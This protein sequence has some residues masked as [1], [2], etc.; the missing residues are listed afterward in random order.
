MKVKFEV[1]EHFLPLWEKK[2]RYMI[3]MGGRGRGASMAISQYLIS[4]LVS[5]GYVRVAIMRSIYSDIRHSCWKELLD[6]INEQEIR[7][8]L[9][10]TENDMHIAYKNNSIQA[11][12]FR[13]SSGSH[14]AKLKSLA[15]YNIVW[16]EEAE[17]ISEQ[18]FIVLD[19]TLRTTK[20]NIL[21][22][23]S[24][25]P[26][27]KNHWIIQKWFTLTKIDTIPN[28]YK[29][30]LN[31]E[32]KYSYYIGG[33]FQD[34]FFNLDE[35]TRDKYKTYKE[36]KPQYYYQ[37]IAG[38]VPEELRGKIF[39]GWKQIDTIPFGAKLVSFGLDGGWYP[40]P[41]ALVAV[42][43]HPVEGYIIDELL[44]GTEIDNETIAAS[45]R[46]TNK[47]VLC[48]ADLDDRSID[49]LKKLGVH[50]TKVEKAPDSV[51]Y[52]IKLTARQKI[53]VTSR[54]VNV[55]KA[56]EN[57]AWQETKDGDPVG[58]PNHYLSDA[59]DAVMYG[60][61]SL[62]QLEIE[63]EDELEKILATRKEI[64]NRPQ[65]NMPIR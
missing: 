37:M 18:E 46:N 29:A 5:K 6:R 20:G 50:I 10:I 34:N 38:F 47:N 45:I 63:Y 57:Y 16:I 39:S 65:N 59:C 23:L 36:T 31:G 35:I 12:G 53:S 42:Y 2:P 1:R 24:L 44:F 61:Q 30:T 13:Q 33:T 21:I 8:I 51:K 40:D 19:D 14:S 4:R 55:W 52:R 41:T 9:K 15:S 28:F 11:I 54:S 48:N 56:Y 58:K 49:S 17:E 32:D 60:L 22:I 62:P 64:S 26:P 3:C 27:H 43:S 25:N 7:P